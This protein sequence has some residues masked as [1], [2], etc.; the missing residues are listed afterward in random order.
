[1][2]VK[3]LTLLVHVLDRFQAQLHSDGLEGLQNLLSHEIVQHPGF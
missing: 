1:M 3:T 2:A